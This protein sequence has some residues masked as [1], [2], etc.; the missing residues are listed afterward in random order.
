SVRVFE[1][2][3]GRGGEGERGESVRVFECS[4]GRG[5]EGERGESVRVFEGERGRGG[6]GERG[7]S[8]R[9]FEGENLPC[10]EFSNYQFPITNSRLPITH[11][12]KELV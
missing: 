5:G 12:Q 4:R 6:E 2:E 3:R 11:Y 10:D 9:V 7:E 8:V 1:G